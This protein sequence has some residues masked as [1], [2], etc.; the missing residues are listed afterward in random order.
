MRPIFAVLVIIPLSGISACDF[1]PASQETLQSQHQTAQPDNPNELLINEIGED[2]NQKEKWSIERR[3]DQAY[4]DA[5]GSDINLLEGPEDQG[6]ISFICDLNCDG[7]ISPSVLF[8]DYRLLDA[9][10]CVKD[11]RENWCPIKSNGKVIAVES[12]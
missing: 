12:Q 4:I 8:D 11:Y 9:G 3:N 7:K 10:A 6:Y 1:R 2:K 5:L